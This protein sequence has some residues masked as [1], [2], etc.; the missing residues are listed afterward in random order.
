MSAQTQAGNRSLTVVPLAGRRDLDRFIDLPRQLYADDPCFIAPL[1]VEQRQR[2]APDSAYAAHARWQGWLALAGERPVGRITAQ[3]DS[4]E[5]DPALGY[6]GMLEA[7]RPDAVAPL[8]AAA[9][10]W[11]R[12]EGKTR[13]RGPLNLHINEEVGL[14]VEGFDTPPVVLM[15]HGRP[16]YDGALREAG[17]EGVKDLLAYRTR[18]DFAAPKI[19]SRLAER[20]SRRVSIRSLRRG[21]LDAETETMRW[22][23]DDAWVNNWGFAPLDPAG[24]ADTVKT[25]AKLLPADYI[26]FAEVDGEPIA[27]IVALPNL[28]EA[29]RDLDGRLL[30]FGWLRFLWRLKV[31]GVKSAR[32]PLMGVTRAYQHSRLGPTVAFMIIDAV[33]KALHR[34]GV[35]AVEMG[36][37]LEDNAGMRNIIETIGGEAYKRY[38]VYEKDL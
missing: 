34:R 17:F 36:W 29:A 5:R 31:S 35:T 14:L 11:L 25:L 18:P 28:N 33:R 4:L 37:I 22:I 16:W 38:R 10:A 24:W 19:M 27:F 26:Q 13:V 15:G 9:A 21:A 23:F 32:V 1:A 6:F 30:P 3:V 7:D 8:V 20:A 2:F 12:A